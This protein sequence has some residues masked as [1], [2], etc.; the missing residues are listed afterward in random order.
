MKTYGS[1]ER[2]QGCSEPRES[3]PFIVTLEQAE[4]PGNDF[5]PVHRAYYCPDC[6]EELQA[7]GMDGV[8]S[9]MRED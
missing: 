2:C 6:L 9:V 5:D 3:E 8:E 4:W 1:P 7:I